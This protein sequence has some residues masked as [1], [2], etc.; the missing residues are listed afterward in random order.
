MKHTIFGKTGLKV[1]RTGF[2]CIPIQRIPY[3]EST[4]L[5]RRAYEGGV[6]LFDTAHGYTT[7]QDRIGVALS[8]VRDKIVLCTKSS[9]PTPEILLEHL[10]NAL[11][12]MRTDYIDVFQFHNPNFVPKPGGKDGLYDTLVK[13]KS[14]GKILF[15]GITAHK[16]KNAL[17]AVQSDLY[18]TLQYPFSYLSTD[19]ELALIAQCNRHNVGILAMKGLAGGLLSN[20]K[21]AFAF[22]R[23]YESVV[24]IWGIEK[25]EQLE[26]FLSY[27]ANPPKMDDT[28]QRAI[29]LDRSKLMGSFCRSCGYCLPCPANIE[30]PQA[31]RMSFLMGRTLM[32]KFV[33][34]EW[35]Q[36]MRNIDNCTGCGRCIA[37]CPYELNVPELL[38]SQQEIYF[39]DIKS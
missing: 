28:M 33:S 2:G 21:A 14:Q 17:E 32:D 3:D 13:A 5:L 4:A 27:E 10:D 31:A 30:I 15:I 23:Q 38:K 22:L 8:Q 9:A 34:E 16:R 18:D 12:T 26:E 39:E 25:M 37:H 20:A 7:S 24:P 29:D 35:Q 11:K 1:S 6:T 36:N 19:D